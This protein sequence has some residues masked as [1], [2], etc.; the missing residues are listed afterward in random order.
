M[1]PQRAPARAAGV[2]LR[3]TALAAAACALAPA[4]AA[5]AAVDNNATWTPVLPA[6]PWPARVARASVGTL[7]A[8][9][10]L[11]GGANASAAL[12]DVWRSPDGGA[13]WTQVLAD[14]AGVAGGGYWP[15]RTGGCVVSGPGY[16]ALLGG[17][18]RAPGAP[19]AG[20]YLSDTWTSADGATWVNASGG[21]GVGTSFPGRSGHACAYHD[22]GLWVLGGLAPA[23]TN[24][25]WRA[26]AATAPTSGALWV[27]VSA[28]DWAP[29]AYAAAASYGGLLWVVGGTNLTSPLG[30]AWSSPDGRAWTALVGVP[31]TPRDSA[32]LVAWAGVLWLLGGRTATGGGGA[33]AA[34]DTWRTN[35]GSSG[36]WG[37]VEAGAP[38]GPRADAGCAAVAAGAGGGAGT[39]VLLGGQQVAGGAPPPAPS[40]RGDV[41]AASANL[42][43]EEAGVVCGGHGVCN[44]SSW[45][46]A[47]ATAT[48]ARTAAGHTTNHDRWTGEQTAPAGAAAGRASAW[49]P[50]STAAAVLAPAPAPL[51]VN[52]TCDDGWMDARCVEPLCN[53]R[54]CVHGT[55]VSANATR[56][57]G[58][59]SSTSPSLSA[60]RDTCVCDDPTQWAGASCDTPVCAAA[61]S[62]D[63]GGC[64]EPGG[65]DCDA[66]WGGPS[67]G[68]P[69]DPL[70][71]VGVWVTAHVAGVY[72]SLTTLGFAAVLGGLFTARFPGL[73]SA[74]VGLPIPLG[75][76]AGGAGRYATGDGSEWYAAAIGG[77]GGAERQGLLPPRQPPPHRQHPPQLRRGQPQRYGSVLDDDP[78]AA[79]ISS[80]TAS[81]VG[82]GSGGASAP[83][84]PHRGGGGGSP[85]PDAGGGN[86]SDS[87]GG[88]GTVTL[89]AYALSPTSPA[90]QG[91][92]RAASA[93]RVRFAP[94][95]DYS[96]V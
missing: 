7:G 47:A 59:S 63:H 6:A 22:G 58:G 74:C 11:V 75:G 14:G 17:Y 2:L 45:V 93:K 3:T 20:R 94:T 64:S 80:A 19:G 73:L 83:A 56:I 46:P 87:G 30:D 70:H 72:V 16:L 78:T 50:Y 44:G 21:G 90:L 8:D 39:L 96:S 36:E 91:L 29:R 54:T 12:S 40:L 77:G 68:I 81:A 18:A 79:A 49:P 38:W 62:P 84:P 95:V 92:T 57:I 23:P 67:C 5:A 37:L 52:C 13:S 9:V 71:V 61:C 76:G 28:G 43:C 15:P 27:R 82:G 55:C 66:G 65:C 4:V 24:D 86:S 34:G 41:W 33:Y 48:A 10:F 60:G 1:A 26:D 69:L 32:C 53:P 31:W 51:P 88:G 42:L 89:G 25:V 85:A 35:S